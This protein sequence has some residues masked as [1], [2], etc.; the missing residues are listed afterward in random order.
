MG[1][2]LVLGATSDIA[3]AVA[4]RFAEEGWKLIL[5]AR[6]TDS[7]ERISRDIQVRSGKEV[8]TACFDVMDIDSHKTF[9]EKLPERQWVHTHWIID[10][11]QRIEWI[12]EIPYKPR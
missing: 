2:M 8:M 7:L 10:R 9:W 1:C 12:M 11:L 4:R 3:S 5:A 6:N